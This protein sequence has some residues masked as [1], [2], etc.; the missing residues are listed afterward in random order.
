[1]VGLVS[2]LRVLGGGLHN[3]GF[4]VFFL[5][6]THD[7][8]LSRAA[9]SLAFSLARAQGAIEG[10]FVGYLIDRYGPR[11]M[12]CIGALLTGVGYILFAW[13]DSYATFLI[14]YLGVI[15]LSFSPGFV[16]APMAVGNTW[17]IR[18]RARAMTVISSAVPVGGMLITPLLALAVQTWGWRWGAILSGSLFLLI[19]IPLGLGVHPSPE[20]MGLLP[21][22]QAPRNSA[23]KDYTAERHQTV[24]P[25]CDPTLRQA[26]RTVVFWLFVTAM[27]VRVGVY[28][29]ISVHFIPLMV[30]KG[31][32][33]EYGAFLLA[34]FAFLNWAVHF[35]VG[36]IADAVNRPKLLSWCM[37]IA[38]GGLLSLQQGEGVWPLWLFT[39]LFTTIDST[40]PVVWATIGDFY[41]RRYFATIRGTM[42]F[43]YTWG[44]VIGPVSAGA[45]YDREQ[46][47]D[48]T[49]WGLMAIM[50][51]GAALTAFLIQ[52]WARIHTDP[53]TGTR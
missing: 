43:F 23:S 42:S 10:P 3:Y 50:M 17:F 1:M 2:A 7:L 20:S 4:T 5:P 29:T 52:P 12:I 49:L 22:G 26:M 31:Q 28:T 48:S 11:P 24:E 33:P 8:D 36:W 18:W 44:A 9:T 53:R 32:T 37:V 41:G 14:V 39:I 19:G 40:F 21:D 15:S 35:L 45:L 6:L 38:A 51:L 47:Y 30:W 16:H 25:S 27:L 46:S 34:A 13:V